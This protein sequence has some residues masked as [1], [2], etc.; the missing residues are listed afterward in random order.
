[1][2]D[3]GVLVINWLSGDKRKCEDLLKAVEWTI[4]PVW[5]LPGLKT[6]NILYFAAVEKI[7]RPEIVSAAADIQTEI[8]FEN[9]LRQLV[10]RLQNIHR[11][12]TR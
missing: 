2:L 4:G 5:K 1:M 10:Q 3:N 9:S 8:P 7:T 6:H 11:K 12:R